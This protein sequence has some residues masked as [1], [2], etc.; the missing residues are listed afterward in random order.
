VSKS[1]AQLY[2][3]EMAERRREY[4]REFLYAIITARDEPPG[5]FSQEAAR[6]IVAD[7][8]C[9][10]AVRYAETLLKRLEGKP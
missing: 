3:E 5:E 8:D 2:A 10:L 9:D 6:Q 7:V 1:K 4:A